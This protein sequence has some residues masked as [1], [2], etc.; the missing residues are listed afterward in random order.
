VAL[1]SGLVA[2][3]DGARADVQPARDRA[4][5]NRA[6]QI[7][8]DGEHLFAQPSF[9]A[10]FAPLEDHSNFVDSIYV[11]NDR[12]RLTVDRL[13]FASPLREL[14]FSF[15]ESVPGSRHN[16]KVV[17][18][19]PNFGLRKKGRAFFGW[20][21]GVKF[22][23]TWSGPLRC[24]DPMIV[25][26]QN[27]LACVISSS[28]CYPDILD[29]LDQVLRALARVTQYEPISSEYF[30][31]SHD[32][33]SNLASRVGGSVRTLHRR[34]RT[35]TGFSPKRFLAMQ[36]FRRSV[37]EIATRS[38]GLSVIAFNLGFSDQAHMTREFRRHAGVTPGAFKQAWRG[39]HARAVRF[40][41]DAGPSTRLR[42]AVWPLETTTKSG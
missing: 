19:E 37:Y 40:L 8:E 22:K 34:M 23:P 13:T 42:M 5:A 20:I 3:E 4:L 30:E 14:A 35:S 1:V 39:R 6:I 28:P 38:G 17:V 10:E 24:D 12:G 16:G 25:A 7:V 9:Y 21:I 41:Q 36:R 26:C 32:R 33:V 11:L 29:P 31:T 15:R 2:G 18:N 27:S